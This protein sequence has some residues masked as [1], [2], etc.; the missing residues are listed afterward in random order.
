M[1]LSAERKEWYFK[2]LEELLGSYSKILLVQCDN[3]GSRQMAQIRLAL[4]GQ[5]VVLLGKNTMIR[6][7]LTNYIKQN[8]GHPYE[9]LIPRVRG[10]VGFIFTNGD[11]GKVREVIEENRVPAP[12]RVGAVAPVDVFV[13]PGPTGCDPGQTSFFQV[14]QIP[15]KIAKGQIEIT[16]E[17]HLVKKG[18]KVGNSEAVLLTRLSIRP[19][20]YGLVIELVYDNGSIFEA[21]VLDLTDDD[22]RA[23]FVGAVRN[24]AAASLALGY[25][26]LASLP[27]SIANAFKALVA[28]AVQC[29]GVTFAQAEP[30]KK[31]LPAPAGA[32]AAAAPTAAEEEEEE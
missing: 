28:V 31:L 32:A 25:P 19:F 11:L 26:T 4:R 1:P 15:T 27:H 7:I 9:N 30:F 20:T 24:V 18:D 29:P 2:R 22:L 8:P 13:P 14:L 10:N 16:N 17:V 6:K 5:A 12:A 21:A 23:R 3:V